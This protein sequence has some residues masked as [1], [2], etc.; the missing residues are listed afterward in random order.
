M[1]N[2]YGIRLI[3]E[4]EMLKEQ[5]SVTSSLCDSADGS[6]IE[7]AELNHVTC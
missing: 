2:N 7:A 3:L 6:T 4:Y 1:G 5:R